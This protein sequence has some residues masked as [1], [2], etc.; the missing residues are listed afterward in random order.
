[1]GRRRTIGESRHCPHQQCSSTSKQGVRVLE[2]EQDGA[3][4]EEVRL[5][6]VKG[7]ALTVNRKTVRKKLGM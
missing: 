5:W 7:G 1:V 6:G 4:E 3:E 2:V